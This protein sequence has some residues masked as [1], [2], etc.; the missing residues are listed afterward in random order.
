MLMST[1]FRS[2]DINYME[3][4]T[5]TAFNSDTFSMSQSGEGYHHFD[6][7]HFVHALR[8][9][10]VHFRLFLVIEVKVK[11]SSASAGSIK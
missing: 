10:L 9:F 4:L 11:L 7:N 1:A 6:I 3:A 2:K 8:L 5:G